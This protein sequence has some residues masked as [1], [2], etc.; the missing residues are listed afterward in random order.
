MNIN[1][2]MMQL[3]DIKKFIFEKLEIIK[4]I[5]KKKIIFNHKFKE[6]EFISIKI[7]NILRNR[8]IKYSFIDNSKNEFIKF[9]NKLL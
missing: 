2:K 6:F 3:K 9:K 7:I 5:L 1:E 4:I 8:K